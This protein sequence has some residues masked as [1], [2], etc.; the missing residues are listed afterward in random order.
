V[1]LFSACN[2]LK[3]YLVNVAPAPIFAGLEG[4]DNGMVGGVVVFGGVRVL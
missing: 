2:G 1:R 3:H 4:L